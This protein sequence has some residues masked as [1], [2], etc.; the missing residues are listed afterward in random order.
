M[1]DPI[2]FF[3]IWWLIFM[4]EYAIQLI[5]YDVSNH[6]PLVALLKNI[7]SSLLITIV[8]YIILV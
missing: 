2:G 4:I 8:V 5:G 6:K 3:M 1:K 7:A